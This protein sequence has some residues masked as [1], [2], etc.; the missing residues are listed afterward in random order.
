MMHSHVKLQSSWVVLLDL[1]CLLVSIM[2]A[3]VLRFGPD[4]M[5]QYVFARFDG[6]VVFVGRILIAN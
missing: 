3:V 2:L 5:A 6:W 4:E 1:A